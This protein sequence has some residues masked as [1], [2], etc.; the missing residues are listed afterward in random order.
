MRERVGG[1][2]HDDVNTEKYGRHG[3]TQ[4]Q[5]DQVLESDYMVIRNK[6]GRTDELLLIGR[7]YGGRCIAVPT[8]RW[9]PHGFWRPVTAYPCAAHEERRPRD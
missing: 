7:D 9:G 6:A 4:R 8:Q 3:L 2:F 1:C 5:I